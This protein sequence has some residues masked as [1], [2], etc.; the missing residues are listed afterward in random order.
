MDGR[1]RTPW[2]DPSRGTS[3]IWFSSSYYPH[4]WFPGN[5]YLA[6]IAWRSGEEPLILHLTSIPRWD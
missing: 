6:R 5:H 3:R 2:A 1:N 4:S